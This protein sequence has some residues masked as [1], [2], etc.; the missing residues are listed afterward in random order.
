M[1]EL[2]PPSPLNLMAEEEEKDV[3]FRRFKKT[4]PFFPEG[5]QMQPRGKEE[6]GNIVIVLYR[7]SQRIWL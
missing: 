2:S 6:E 7:V 4:L 3:N 1:S 5:H